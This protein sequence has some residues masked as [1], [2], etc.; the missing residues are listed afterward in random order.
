MPI[1]KPNEDSLPVRLMTRMTNQ[2][3]VHVHQLSTRESE[4]LANNFIVIVLTTL[5]TKTGDSLANPKVTLTWLMIAIGAHPAA[6]ALLVPIRES[7]SLIPQILFAPF[8]ERQHHLGWVYR[9]GTA[10]Q[11]LSMVA[12]AMT[13]LWFDAQVAGWI[14]L[15][16]LTV[17]S[18]AR[19]ACSL[20]SKS[21]LGELIVKRLRGQT[22]G[23]AASAAGL[24]TLLSGALFMMISG[25]ESQTAMVLL[26]LFAASAWAVATVIFS[27]LHEPAR[28]TTA[29]GRGASKGIMSRLLFP[30][31]HDTGFRWFVVT[32]VLLMSSALVAPFYIL[33]A[34]SS[35]AGLISFGALLIASGLASLVSAPVWGRFADFSSRRVLMIAS[36]LVVLLGA[37]TAVLWLIDRQFFSA[38]WTVPILYFGL[39]LAHQGVRIGRKTYL[40]DLANDD[41]RVDYIAVSNTL[42]G[43][44]LLP[45]GAVAGLLASILEPIY[46]ILLFSI[47]TLIGAAFTQRLPEV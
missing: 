42:I 7:G 4:V 25:Q 3:A 20:A 9:W 39:E 28:E 5:F 1:E 36:L 30:L 22:A 2:D 45:V 21:I 44:A 47:T 8:V 16:L 31:Q 12:I 24:I 38:V 40:V 37:I 29:R 17:F 15:V 35:D 27:G 26:V 23:W 10:I 43:L 33:L 41:N 6:I 32:R 19:C 14:I 18:L 46:M 11:G 34:G 13:A